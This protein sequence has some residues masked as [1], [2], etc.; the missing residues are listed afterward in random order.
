MPIRKTKRVSKRKYKGGA[1]QVVAQAVQPQAVAQQVVAQPQPQIIAQP[2][3]PVAASK[4]RQFPKKIRLSVTPDFK[5]TIEAVED[6]EYILGERTNAAQKYGDPDIYR[7]QFGKDEETGSP[8]DVYTEYVYERLKDLGQKECKMLKHRGDKPVTSS[9]FL[10][11][12]ASSTSRRQLCAASIKNIKKDDNRIL[13]LWATNVTNNGIKFLEAV[14]AHI[15]KLTEEIKDLQATKKDSVNDL[16]DATATLEQNLSGITREVQQRLQEVTRLVKDKE[17]KIKSKVDVEI[18]EIQKYLD[19][20]TQ[21]T[22]EIE[23]LE[24]TIKDFDQKIEDKQKELLKT[25]NGLNNANNNLNQQ[26]TNLEKLLQEIEQSI[27][28]NAFAGGKRRKKSKRSKKKRSKKK[29]SKKKRSK[30]K[31]RSRKKRGG[32][33]VSTIKA[34]KKA[35]G[36]AL[37]AAAGVKLIGGKKRRKRGGGLVSTLKANKKALGAAVGAAAGVA[38]IGGKKKKS[39]RR[40]GRP[41]KSN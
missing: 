2:P 29:R 25:Q 34:N 13:Q 32:G 30:K 28:M 41:C 35:L 21:V 37:G 3:A 40:V 15:E 26:G 20:E 33:L 18:A 36:A 8:I 27:Q 7:G 39:K 12:G 38:L 14:Q 5:S 19:E 24:A 1:D 16:K 31:K 10:G 9:G 11:L 17:E 4:L 6:G 23:R 22:V